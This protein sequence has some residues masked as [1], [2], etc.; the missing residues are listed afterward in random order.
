ML[1]FHL[2]VVICKFNGRPINFGSN[3]SEADIPVSKFQAT[4]PFF[5]FPFVVSP[6]TLLRRA[7]SNH[8]HTAY[9]DEDDILVMRLS[10]KQITC[11]VSKN[12]NTHISNAEDGSAV[13]VVL[14]HYSSIETTPSP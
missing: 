10:D 4:L 8:M 1:R 13:E 9:F 5:P 3:I 6:S 2:P 11:E 7:L 14:F 12:W